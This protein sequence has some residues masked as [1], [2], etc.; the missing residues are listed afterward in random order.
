MLFTDY[1]RVYCRKSLPREAPDALAARVI[2]KGDLVIFD[3]ARNTSDL[4]RPRSASYKGR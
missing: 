1:S 4:L 2:L 3:T